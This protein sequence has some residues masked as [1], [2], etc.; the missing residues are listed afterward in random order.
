M[1]KRGKKSNNKHDKL[2]G[3]KGWLILVTIGLISIS[4]MYFLFSLIQIIDILLGNATFEVILLLI[5]SIIFC[6]LFVYCLR[7]ELKHKKEFPTWFISSLWVSSILGLI[8]GQIQKS[9]FSATPLNFI[10]T[11]L[12]TLYFIK[13]KRVRNTFVK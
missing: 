11:I 10:G 9:E 4:L 7:L 5:F 13:S 6:A 8:I 12:W 1:K 2:K 3:L